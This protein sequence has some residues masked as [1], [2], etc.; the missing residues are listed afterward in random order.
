[1]FLDDDFLLDND[2]SKRLYHNYVEG[3]PIVDYHCHLEPKEIFENKPFKNITQAWL[4]GDHYKWR[5][6]RANGVNENLITGSADDYD[7]FYAWADTIESSIG[8]PLYVWTHLELKRIFNIDERLCRKN[9]SQIWEKA[10][11]KLRESDLCPRDIIEKMNVKTICTTDDPVSSLNYHREIADL[12]IKFNVLPAFRPDRIISIE[13]DSFNQYMEK[14]G[15]SVSNKIETYTDLITAIKE[16]VKYFNKMGC[17]LSDHSLSTLKGKIP[18]RDEMN[19]IFSLKVNNKEITQKMIDKYHLGLLVDLM[20]I[21]HE[22]NWTCQIHLLASRN[23]NTRLFTKLGPDSGGD[24]INDENIIDPISDLLNALN[25]EEKLPKTII[26]SVN[27]NYWLSLA[28]LIGCF[29]SEVRGKIQLGAAWWFN[30]TYYGMRKQ[31]ITLAENGILG[32]FVGMLT[33]SRSFLSYP[34]HEYFRR[35]LCQLIGQWVI[36]GQL[37]DDEDYLGNILKDISVNNA[38]NY[39]NFSK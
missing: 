28:A 1:M 35:I 36:E 29:Q 14:L 9:A 12:N 22:F 11:K 6:M 7:K 27:P 39:F 38:I 33:D 26:Y 25:N 32:N 13:N 18:S 3:L 16:R 15:D 8:N 24:A 17:R 20:R 31:L 21:Y 30:D 37:P 23:N 5:L 34:R 2:V 10:N 19:Q 4:G